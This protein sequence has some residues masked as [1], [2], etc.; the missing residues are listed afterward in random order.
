MALVATHGFAGPGG[1][2][3]IP[4]AR[5]AEVDANVQAQ[6]VGQEM[7]EFAAWMRGPASHKF[8]RALCQPG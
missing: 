4:S 6:L 1:P 7:L 3:T 8:T 2:V 5:S